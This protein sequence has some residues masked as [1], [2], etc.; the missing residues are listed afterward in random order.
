[1]D[2]NKAIEMFAQADIWTHNRG[3]AYKIIGLSNLKVTRPGWVPTVVYHPVEEPD[4]W[5][6]RPIEDFLSSC[7][8]YLD[9]ES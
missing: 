6:T 3:Q 5:Y 4:N 7:T 8:P 1:M 2:L 9:S